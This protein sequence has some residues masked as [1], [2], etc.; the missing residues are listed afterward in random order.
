MTV[1]TF[2]LGIDVGTTS[3]KVVLADPAVGVVA[4]A[5]EPAAL[6]SPHPGWAEADPAQWWANLASLVPAVLAAASAATGKPVTAAD[7]AAV[8]TT[9]MVPAVIPADEA[10]RP[11]RSAILQNDAR[12]T[13]EIREL[14]AALP[15]LDFVA[16]TG[17]ALTQQSVGP[18]L[19]W[20]ARHEPGAWA[21]A[22]TVQGS[23][24]WLATRLG[25]APH[26]ERNWALESGLF[27]LEPD[28]A[29]APLHDPDLR[30][31]FLGLHLGHTRGDMYRAI[32]E[33][34]AYGFR[35]HA[36]IF[37][38]RSVALRP[39]A[40]VS[41]GGSKSVVWKQILADALGVALEPVLDH[42]GAALGA[43]LAAAVGTGGSDTPS[44]KAWAAAASVPGMV[45]IGAP[46][47]PDPAHA[48]RYAEAYQIYR[49]AGVALTPISHRLATRSVS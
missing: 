35:H 18:T 27:E 47:E 39:A 10:G 23:Y 44:P 31:A 9:G 45:T 16:R 41:N 37:A 25:A 49:D 32:L 46:I 29:L 3:T 8:A 40:R 15:G 5:S 1:A 36:D 14:A 13:A 6:S 17:S 38:D 42:P 24:D 26:V 30:G 7:I 12:A 43:A 4:Q 22:A 21:A 19:L 20:L 28:G 2:V 34:I 33:G 11:L 48:A